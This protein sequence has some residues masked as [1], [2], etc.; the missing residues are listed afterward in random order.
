[1]PGLFALALPL[2]SSEQHNLHQLTVW[3]KAAGLRRD[4]IHHRAARLPRPSKTRGVIW[5]LGL[6]QP[7]GRGA[8]HLNISCVGLAI[9]GRKTPDNKNNFTAK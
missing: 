5:F 3:P 9:W 2:A 4:R 1:M 6:L 8:K 7:S